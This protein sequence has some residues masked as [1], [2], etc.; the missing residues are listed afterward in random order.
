[1]KKYL[2]YFNFSLLLTPLAITTIGIFVLYSIY[3]STG[4]PFFERQII[5]LVLSLLLFF[6]FSLINYKF[7]INISPSLYLILLL[8]LTGLIFFGKNIAGTKSWIGIG[9]VGIQPSEFGKIITILLIAKIF[10][11]YYKDG[12][13]FIDFS[14][15]S[16]IVGL[17]ILLI[18][19]GN[20]MGT[21]LTYTF[22]LLTL[23][24]IIRV[25]KLLLIIIVISTILFSIA[26]W[27]FVLKDY[28]KKRI[29]VFLH[30]QS[31]PL[32]VGYH[33]IQSKITIGSGG[34]TGK[35]FLKGTQ[36]KLGFLPAQ[37]TD[38]ILSVFAEEF[39]F[40]GV[41]ILLL[42]YA[43]LFYSLFRTAYISED[44]CTLLLVS[45]ILGQIFF[46]FLINI[47]VSL[48]KL[49][50]AGI[51]LPLFSYGGSSLLT[52]YSLLGLAEN[53]YILKYARE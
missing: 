49:P 38:F 19:A 42:L 27:N 22:I 17:P 1:M 28:Q 15:A 52:V 31:D 21:A 44:I 4:Q 32:G 29:K 45:L 23:I 53:A 9:G 36:K 20:D 7:F 25:K 16:I 43:Y 5:W 13:N 39:G 37:H 33:T 8:V 12:L 34:T 48:G 51:T 2:K 24:F 26:S 10:R 40:I 6:F 3:K 14:K 50:V 30:P 46:Q 35:G 47:L 41:M 11:K 18:V